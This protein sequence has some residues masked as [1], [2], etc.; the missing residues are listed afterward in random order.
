MVSWL[1]SGN[2]FDLSSAIR[3]VSWLTDKAF[4]ASHVVWALCWTQ[5]L[6]SS[7]SLSS[8]RDMHLL[9]ELLVHV[10][11]S[12]WKKSQAQS[13]LAAGGYACSGAL[14][15]QEE[16]QREGQS[17]C[18]PLMGWLRSARSA[19]H[20]SPAG[21]GS[22]SPAGHKAAFVEPGGGDRHGEWMPQSLWG[23]S[24]SHNTALLWFQFFWFGNRWW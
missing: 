14:E 17:L 24:A 12:S 15:K 22:R 2:N 23:V 7:C 20:S 18:A 4:F 21:V 1:F 5:S 16:K 3:H 19:L 11:T 8:P 9:Y 10:H 13:L 6:F